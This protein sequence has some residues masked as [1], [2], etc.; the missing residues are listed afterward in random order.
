[1][2]CTWFSKRVEMNKILVICQDDGDGYTDTSGYTKWSIDP[3]FDISQFEMYY[4][5]DTI[6]PLF[7]RISDHISNF[8]HKRNDP[9]RARWRPENAEITIQSGRI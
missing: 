6:E 2:N 7:E 3:V 9:R 4:D 8:L 5:E 1:M